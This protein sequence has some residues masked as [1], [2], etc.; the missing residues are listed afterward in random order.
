MFLLHACLHSFSWCLC[1][2]EFIRVWAVSMATLACGWTVISAVVIAV[3]VPSAPPMA[4]LSS[5][6]RKTSPLIQWKCGRSEN[7]Q[8][9][10]R[11]EFLL[12]FFFSFWLFCLYLTAGTIEADRK[13]RTGDVEVMW[14]ANHFPFRMPL[15]VQFFIYLA[16][17]MEDPCCFQMR[18][19]LT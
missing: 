18:S 10:R 3:H 15:L 1:F 11:S 6:E 7:P 16:S 2:A 4:A 13:G 12:L 8:N 14:Y 17:D 9:H 19:C 5:L